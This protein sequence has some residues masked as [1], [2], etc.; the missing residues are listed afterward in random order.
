MT[1][2]C[3]IIVVVI[4]SVLCT[5][6]PIRAAADPIEKAM[7]SP[8]C[9]E[10]W[11]MGEKVTLYNQDALF[12][13]INGES[14]MYF[15]YGFEILASARYDNAKN[16]K[17][18]IEADVYRM[19]SLLDAFG[20]Y[21]NYRKADAAP[22]KVGAEGFISPSQLFFYQ[23]RYFVKLQVLG[24]S[25]LD[26]KVLTACAEAIAKNLPGPAERP[27]ELELLMI[28]AVVKQSERYIAQSVLGYAF[29]KRGLV[30][31]AL[32]GDERVKVF[33]VIEDSPD[34]A[35]TALGE[36]E[37]YLRT[38]GKDV[39]VAPKLTALAAD[40]ALYKKVYVAREGRYLI[41]VASEKGYASRPLIG[42]VRQRMNMSR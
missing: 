33:I 4:V 18:A 1:I 41:G 21:A 5:V 31:D 35:R 26:S 23:D 24:T 40:D 36:Y 14:E 22:A 13:R 39:H 42:Q 3:G 19:G 16:P 32:F 37:A 6:S 30:A 38:S 10:G 2:R 12:E 27:G 20:M 29:F 7:P 8:A 25:E 28:P 11:V 17:H 15:P 9:A 34:G